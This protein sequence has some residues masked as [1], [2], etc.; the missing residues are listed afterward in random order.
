M[1]EQ[2]STKE[3]K[4]S[5]SRKTFKEQK[6]FAQKVDILSVCDALSMNLTKKG[7]NIF[8]ADHESLVIYPETNRFHWFSQDLSGDVITFV[9]TFSDRTFKEAVQYLNAQELS[10][11]ERTFLSDK[12]EDFFYYVKE[13]SEAQLSLDYLV[14]ERGISKEIVSQLLAENYLSPGTYQPHFPENKQAYPCVVARWER[15]GKIV[16]GSIQGLTY[17]PNTYGK[18]G[19]DKRIMAKSERH[20]GWNYTIGTPTKMVIAE[21]WIDLLSYWTLHP[22]LDNCLLVDLEGLKE[23]TVKEFLKVLTLEK[24]GNLEEGLIVAVDNDVAGQKFVDK[25]SHYAFSSSPNYQL[26]QPMNDAILSSHF[27]VYQ[28]V[29]KSFDVSPLAIAALHKAFTNGE[30]TNELANPWKN[31]QFFGDVLKPK[32]RP[33]PV[34]LVA[35]CTKAAKALLAVKSEQN[36]YDFNR[37]INPNNEGIEKELM[38]N[39]VLRFYK[40]YQTQGPTLVEAIQKD[41]NDQL[42]AQKEGESRNMTEV[43]NEI[44]LDINEQLTQELVEL[45]QQSPQQGQE[46]PNV[47]EQ[48]LKKD[49]EPAVPTQEPTSSLLEKLTREHQAFENNL[50][51]RPPIELIQQAETIFN[52]TDLYQ[53]LSE[54]VTNTMNHSPLSYKFEQVLT[55]C[56]APIETL[57]HF[58]NEQSYS[59]KD[60]AFLSEA[61]ITHFIQS[62]EEPNFPTLTPKQQEGLTISL[63]SLLEDIPHTLDTISPTNAHRLH[64]QLS[65]LQ[66]QLLETNI[67]AR[68]PQGLTE[69]NYYRG[70]NQPHL[71]ELA[72]HY[73]NERSFENADAMEKTIRLLQSFNS[74]EIV[75]DLD[76]NVSP[77]RSQL[78]AFKK[79]ANSYEGISKDYV[80][81]D[82]INQLTLNKQGKFVLNELDMSFETLEDYLD[83]HTDFPFGQSK[84]YENAELFLAH[85]QD[86]QRDSLVLSDQLKQLTDGFIENQTPTPLGE[87]TKQFIETT[88]VVVLDNQLRIQ[89]TNRLD[90]PLIFERPSAYMEALEKTFKHELTQE[91]RLT[92]KKELQVSLQQLHDFCEL[93]EGTDQQVIPREALMQL[94]VTETKEGDSV[95]EENLVGG[96]SRTYDKISDVLESYAGHPWAQSVSYE[97][98][99]DYVQ[100][101]GEPGKQ[102]Y[103]LAHN[104]FEALKDRYCLELNDTGTPTE[105]AIMWQSLHVV[106][107]KDWQ[108]APSK[109]LFYYQEVGRV[110]N[111]ILLNNLSDVQQFITTIIEPETHSKTPNKLKQL[112]QFLKE[113]PKEKKT[114]IS[115]ESEIDQRIELFI[116][117][118]Q[119]VKI[120]EDS[121]TRPIVP[122][123]ILNEQPPLVPILEDKQ[124]TEPTLEPFQAGKTSKELLQQVKDGV[125]AFKSSEVYKNYL[126]TM[127]KFHRYSWRNI[128]LIQQQ[129]PHATQVAG[130]QKWQKEFGRHVMKGQKGLK[131]LAPIIAHDKN[132]PGKD[133]KQNDPATPRVVGYRPTTV[134]DI[135]QTDGKEL[136]RLVNELEGTITDYAQLFEAMAATTDFDIRFE[137]IPSGAKGYCAPLDKVIAL[138]TGMSEKQTIKTLI[139]EITHSHLHSHSTN[140]QVDRQ[141]M[142]IEAESTAFVV[143]SRFGI[144]TSDYSF[145][146]LTGWSEGKELDTMTQS[147][148]RIQRQADKLITDI[149]ANLT[150]LTKEKNL[151]K[152]VGEKLSQAKETSNEQNNE[153]K[154]SQ[155]KAPRQVPTKTTKERI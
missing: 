43:T 110:N 106:P 22:Q 45:E 12:K 94:V 134:F 53:R 54:Y 14:E 77:K 34:D 149:Q 130:F 127:A 79:W 101:I 113:G 27:K 147:F 95:I 105:R 97:R 36:T 91:Q 129:N 11:V 8:S 140:S 60:E 41:W 68:T 33:T 31:D 80:P 84:A 56:E 125:K 108:A 78:T 103:Q 145:G 99:L 49:V 42:N 10:T 17:D 58:L 5:E 135:K 137:D 100:N 146:Y 40:L 148:A 141:T 3:T 24:D 76:V 104:Q 154:K 28:E 152:G 96:Y 71:K 50:I 82:E 126:T 124:M 13:S 25:L 98:A 19:R 48:P 51:K 153:A 1:A 2:V 59:V 75:T 151:T 44:T 86:E 117:E 128:Y 64:L 67:L 35:E 62:Q 37:L 15:N 89:V 7:R 115:G 69:G 150:T 4:I 73:M 88:E 83:T 143:C 131:I 16:G 63:T 155:A 61:I 72:T 30:A 139:H 121:L 46:R 118:T 114:V 74:Q 81:L 102:V 70:L 32:D 21:S 90:A 132:E 52:R 111:P 133:G 119:T 109:G 93:Y 112:G 26:A 18:R 39:K 120:T 38:V 85:L 57:Q 144:D 87:Q 107:L 136:P 55:Q 142:E 92:K 66:Q 116:Q 20:F 6:A 29:G 122:K 47:T 138:Q 123:E 9:Q 23:N 65:Y